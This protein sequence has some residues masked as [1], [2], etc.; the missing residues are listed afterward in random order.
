MAVSY[1]RDTGQFGGNPINN[2]TG[3]S[4]SFASLPATGNL[5]VVAG[6]GFNG[7]TGTIDISDNQGGAA[8]TTALLVM[9][10]SGT[11]AF[12]KYRENISA[13]SGTFTVTA[14]CSGGS[15]VGSM[16]AFEVSGCATSGSLDKTNSATV[17]GLTA[18]ARTLQPGTTGTLS[19]ANEIA[20][21]A[22]GISNN[23]SI[24][25]S[26]MSVDSSF[27]LQFY[28]N[29]RSSG[30]DGASSY[31]VVSATTAL[32]PTFSWTEAANTAGSAVAVIATF[33][34]PAGGSFPPV[35]ESP[36]NRSQLNALMVQ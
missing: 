7:G 2:S 36:W 21:A 24:N 30:E 35:P 5:I 33:Q 8:Y 20:V 31:L 29:S 4:G 10:G 15:G 28:N 16:I 19:N 9:L 17:T 27:N 26:G 22:I 34:A 18:G 25:N 13:P 1:V 12:V 3:V 32:N 14:K 6:V 11:F 23:S